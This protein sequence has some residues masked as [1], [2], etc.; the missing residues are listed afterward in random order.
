[1]KIKLLI[2]DDH[3]SLREGMQKIFSEDSDIE[4]VEEAVNGLDAILRAARNKPDVVIMDYEMPKYNGIYAAKEMIK[5]QPGLPILLLSMFNDKEHILEAISI[6]VKGYISKE[7]R[8][9]EVLSAVKELYNRGTWF[10]GEV[11]EIITSH[12]IASASGESRVRLNNRLTPRETEITC[13]F[14]EG[15][16]SVDIGNKLNIS[17]RTVEVHKANIFKKL[18]V[19]STI[20]LMRYAIHNHI[21]KIN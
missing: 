9:S 20:E 10:K 11:A 17:K 19:K 16:T 12:L 21:I 13:L 15:K 6:G 14:S 4:S 7:A 5:Q 2:A 3:A 18:N 8:M 1:L